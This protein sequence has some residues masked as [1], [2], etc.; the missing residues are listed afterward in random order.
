MGG[1]QRAADEQKQHPTKQ[2]HQPEG[3]RQRKQQ[4]HQAS[5]TI[6]PSSISSNKV[7]KGAPRRNVTA[8]RTTPRHGRW[9]Y[10]GSMAGQR[11][12]RRIAESP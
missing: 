5:S 11:A 4:Q 12:L 3:Q 8:G 9:W 6:V 1:G 10:F 7:G 2:T